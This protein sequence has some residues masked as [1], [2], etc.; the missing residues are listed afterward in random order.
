MK[1][2]YTEELQQVW[3]KMEEPTMIPQDWLDKR[4]KSG[5]EWCHKNQGDT[6]SRKRVWHAKMKTERMP[7]GRVF[8]FRVPSCP[9]SSI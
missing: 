7:H 5:R 1:R 3:S 6:V 2:P 9:H 4:K 8:L